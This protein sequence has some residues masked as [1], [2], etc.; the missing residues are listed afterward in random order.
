MLDRLV[1]LSMLIAATSIFVYYTVWTLFMP[2]VDDDHFLH[3]LFLPR[4][5]AIRIPVILIILGSTVVGS[6]LSVVMI[7]SNRKKA[8]KAQQKKAS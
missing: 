4:V 7:K 3:N 5:W 2:F 6:F 8:L 1:G